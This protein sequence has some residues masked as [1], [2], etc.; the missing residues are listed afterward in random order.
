MLL[1]FSFMF[2]VSV[3]Q[4]VPQPWA[5]SC[6]DITSS[7]PTVMIPPVVSTQHVA[8]GP[9]LGCSKEALPKTMTQRPRRSRS[10]IAPAR[11]HQEAYIRGPRRSLNPLSYSAGTD[12][13]RPLRSSAIR[14]NCARVLHRCPEE[15]LL[16][17]AH[18]HTH[19]LVSLCM[20][21]PTVFTCMKRQKTGRELR[22]ACKP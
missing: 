5:V 1:S 11:F 21:S 19:R 16:A 15:F 14:L 8:C 9:V 3:C 7:S 18:T 22:D 10:C 6:R 12:P 17:C 20:F 13:S 4:L 2:F